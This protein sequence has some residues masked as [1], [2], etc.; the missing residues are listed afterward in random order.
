MLKLFR[1]LFL[2]ALIVAVALTGALFSAPPEDRPKMIAWAKQTISD[3][4]G[5]DLVKFEKQVEEIVP[6]QVLETFGRI[7]VAETF[8]QVANCGKTETTALEK[9]TT[10][11]I[12]RWID[13]DGKLHFSDVKPGDTRNNEVMT[14]SYADRKQYF[15][16]KI[17]EDTESLP[18][19]TRDKVN[20]EVR[21]VY[22]ILSRDLDIEHLRKVFLN[23]RIIGT[24]A[25][26]QNYRQ[27]KAPRLRTDSGFY[28]SE[29]N[30]AV[31][32]QGNNPEAMRAVIRHE[33]THVIMAGLYGATPSWFN[34]GLAEYFEQLEVSG[35]ARKVGPVDYHWQHLQQR[36]DRGELMA[37]RDY[38][39]LPPQRWY[40]GNL[41][42]NYGM[43]WSLV[44]YL[45]SE[46]KGKAFLQ[47]MMNDMAENYCWSSPGS[48]YFDE[49][50]PGGFAAFEAG[51][52]GWLSQP[53]PTA[54]RY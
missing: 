49:H 32:F 54:H 40:A 48:D 4:L 41:R 38:I 6:E 8:Q 22:R 30:E 17:V 21:Q 31:V 29:N 51:W 35:Q 42:D 1:F 16:L 18:A 14:V 11:E 19:F 45:M 43:A 23:V 28:T 33:A 37:L 15:K 10:S 25:D 3:K 12:Y 44:Y 47:T 34:E 39:N 36:L 52:K 13:E 24:Q 5:Y 53:M 7:K 2:F 46:P 50:Y 26:F 9:S 27:Q 20:A